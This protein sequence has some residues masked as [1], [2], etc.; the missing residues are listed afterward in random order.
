MYLHRQWLYGTSIKSLIR[1]NQCNRH[2]RASGFCCS[3]ETTAFKFQWMI[4]ILASRSFCK[5]QIIS[6]L[7]HFPGNIKDNLHRLSNILSVHNICFHTGK[8]LS[9]KRN[10]PHFFLCHYR[11]R[12]RAGIHN[13]KD[14]IQSLMIRIKHKSIFVRYIFYTV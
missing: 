5:D 11:K 6:S 4:S 10:I 8:N 14:I 12:C 1:I 7:F 13:C 9:Q 2:D 3:F